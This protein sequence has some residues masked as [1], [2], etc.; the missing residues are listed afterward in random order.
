MP[1]LELITYPD[2]RLSKPC[3]IVERFDAAL[4]EFV[5][6]LEQVMRARPGCVGIAAPQV[7]HL[8]RV[9]IVDTSTRAKHR[10]HGR[11]VLVNPTIVKR[12][13]RG[14]LR[15]SCLSIPEFSGAIERARKVAVEAFD[16]HGQR[17]RY[18]CTSY[19]AAAIQHEVDHLDGV[20]FIDHL[21]PSPR[22]FL[23]PSAVPAEPVGS[24]AAVPC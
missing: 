18:S 1:Q 13:G 17:H 8:E 10:S 22:H 4:R 5:T 19:E 3:A 7:G 20:L 2:P 11:L 12:R 6:E 24:K 15:E 14:Y 16:E 23:W 21:S 9:L